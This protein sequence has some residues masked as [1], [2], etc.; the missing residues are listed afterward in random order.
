MSIIA[1]WPT[2][3]WICLLMLVSFHWG[4]ILNA[5][6]TEHILDFDCLCSGITLTWVKGLNCSST[7]V[8]WTNH[9]PFCS[10]TWLYCL[11]CQRASG[12]DSHQR[13]LISLRKGGRYYYIIVI[14][15]FTLRY[16]V[17]WQLNA[18]LNP[19]PVTYSIGY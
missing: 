6:L 5:G 12:C 7:I 11:T 15:L 13:L 3:K 17:A 10:V 9:Q 8:C 16:F 1:E 2:L 18:K 14:T 4:K 19:Y